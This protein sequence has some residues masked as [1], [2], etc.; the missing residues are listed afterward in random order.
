[1]LE[2]GGCVVGEPNF[3]GGIFGDEDFKG[4]VQGNARRS[5]HERRATF[6]I[7]EDE[8]LGVG[9]M[10]VGFFGFAAMIDGS[11]LLAS[12]GRELRGT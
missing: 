7:T 3:A 11:L 5:E 2:V 4:K 8:Q 1:M 6:G 9:H 12:R 10:Q